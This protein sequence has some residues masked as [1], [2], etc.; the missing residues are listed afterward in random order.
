MVAF[1]AGQP[2]TQ[3]VCLPTQFLYGAKGLFILRNRA[4]EPRYAQSGYGAGTAAA[5]TLSKRQW[6]STELYAGS[7]GIAQCRNA[8]KASRSIPFLPS[9][10]RQFSVA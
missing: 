5:A 6:Q 1:P 7:R 3:I 10:V 9:A 4:L 8:G 2:D